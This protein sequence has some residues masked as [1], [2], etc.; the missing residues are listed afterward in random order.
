MHKEVRICHQAINQALKSSDRAKRGNPS[1]SCVDSNLVLNGLL[2]KGQKQ[3]LPGIYTNT[4]VYL[5]RYR[6]DGLYM[7]EKVLSPSIPRN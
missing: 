3:A 7:V 6:Y 5:S 1:G 2:V 4:D